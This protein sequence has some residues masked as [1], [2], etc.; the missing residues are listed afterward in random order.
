MGPMVPSNHKGIGS[1][2][3]P[4]IWKVGSLKGATS[5]P[6]HCWPKAMLAPEAWSGLVA[7]A[8]AG[9]RGGAENMC[10]NAQEGSG[11]PNFNS[12]MRSRITELSKIQQKGSRIGQPKICLHGKKINL[13]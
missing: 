6:I 9:T 11:M 13:N 4:C 5:L 7:T 1:S 12:A 8:V 3:Q 10:S 2:V